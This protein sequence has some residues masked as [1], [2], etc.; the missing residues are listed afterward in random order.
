MPI[1]IAYQSLFVEKANI[2]RSLG[3]WKDKKIPKVRNYLR[4]LGSTL[5]VLESIIIYHIQEALV[6]KK[7]KK[8][9]HYLWLVI[10]W[11]CDLSFLL[12]IRTTHSWGPT[13][14][15]DPAGLLLYLHLAYPFLEDQLVPTTFSRTA[16]DVQTHWPSWQHFVSIVD[17]GQEFQPRKSY[18]L[19]QPTVAFRTGCPALDVLRSL[20]LW[21]L[22]IISRE[23]K[24]HGHLSGIF[25]LCLDLITLNS[26]V[27]IILPSKTI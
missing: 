11:H 22:V 7:K 14:I 8:W 27:S 12:Q 18:S 16:A 6:T 23:N 25:H 19:L 24:E 5:F 17:S 3:N 20:L 1:S 21:R 9:L 2:V 15:L 10:I 4:Y 26:L 13:T